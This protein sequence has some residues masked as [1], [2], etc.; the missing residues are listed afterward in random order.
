[1]MTHFRDVWLRHAGIGV[2]PGSMVP[3]LCSQAPQKDYL[4]I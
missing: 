4:K 1:M 2:N 3:R